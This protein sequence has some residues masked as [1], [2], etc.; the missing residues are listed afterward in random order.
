M[1]K[2]E[3][4][5]SL[6]DINEDACAAIYN[7]DF[8]ELNTLIDNIYSSS[9]LYEDDYKVVLKAFKLANMPFTFN[10]YNILPYDI[11]TSFWG[12]YK[13]I[14]K[15]LTIGIIDLNSF[16]NQ[17]GYANEYEALNDTNNKRKI[18]NR[19]ILKRIAMIDDYSSLYKKLTC[20]YD[21]KAI[22]NIHRTKSSTNAIQEEFISKIVDLV[23]LRQK[24]YFYVNYD[25]IGYDVE[26]LND[27][28]RKKKNNK[29]RLLELQKLTNNI[30]ANNQDI[31]FRDYFIIKD[32]KKVTFTS[33]LKA[34]GLT[35]TSWFDY[36]STKSRK[37]V[38]DRDFYLQLAFFLAIPTSNEIERF[39]NFNGH[40][41]K[42]PFKTYRDTNIFDFDICRW[43]DAGVDFNLINT[44]LGLQFL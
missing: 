21:A 42:S 37:F 41:I 16:L 14:I 17:Y 39:M 10:R 43:I 33:Y 28:L 25:L 26:E 15:D 19:T 31:N 9:L 34:K 20:M 23:N 29:E 1:N 18:Y 22:E 8:K 36:K 6:F 24:F 11:R 4:L 30:F 35:D 7:D 5:D 38:K 12:N 40:S 3:I 32:N 13:G 44:M 27:M 2:F